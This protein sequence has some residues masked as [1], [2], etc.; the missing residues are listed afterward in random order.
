MNKIQ[1][2]GKQF[3]DIPLEKKKFVIKQIIEFIKK[4][5]KHMVQFSESELID[6]MNKALSLLIVTEKYDLLGFAKL[7]PWKVKN[8]IQGY[9]FSSWISKLPNNGIGKQIVNLICVLH[10]NLNHDSDL[11]ATISSDNNIAI[12]TLKKIGATEIPI[13]PYIK[14]L[15]KG[16]PELCLNLK[17]VTN[18]CKNNMNIN[19]IYG[20]IYTKGPSKITDI[21]YW[22]QLP[23]I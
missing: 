14:N 23:I 7:Y 8:K 1:F 6:Y 12:S 11:F 13:P 10:K 21:I 4:H 19:K 22:K 16:K 3:I 18:Y 20:G 5:K 9:E 15:L 17:T 2:I